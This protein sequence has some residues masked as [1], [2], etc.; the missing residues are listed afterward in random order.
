MP[1]LVAAASAP[2][3]YVVDF[4]NPARKGDLSG[5]WVFGVGMVLSFSFLC[6]RVYTK[7]VVARNFAIEDVCL[8]L[9][10]LA[11]VSVQALLVFMWLNKAIGV[12][13]YEM[14]V[15]VFNLYTK[16]IMS[17]FV[18]YVAC[19][20]LSKISL[21]LFYNRLSPVRWFRTAVYFLMF[22]VFAYSIAFIFAL[23][24]PCR[25]VARNWDIRIKDG[26]CINRAAIY[27][28]GAAVNITTD[29][30]LLALPI[31]MIVDL[32]M[33]KIQKAGLIFIF[34][35]G[36]MT[37][38][39]S[40]IRLKVILPLLVDNDETW[41][42]SVPCIWTIVEANLVIICGSFPITRQF[43][44]HVVPRWIGESS[45]PAANS[46]YRSRHPYDLETIGHRSPKKKRSRYGMESLDDGD[47]DNDLELDGRF[48]EHKVEI[49]ATGGE[50]SGDIGEE[51]EDAG[52]ETGIVKTNVTKVTFSKR[53]TWED[54]DSLAS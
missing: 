35:V 31:P 22:I 16:I 25:P 6:M 24:F 9:A 27:T 17:A 2:A 38:V 39:T 5:Y 45:S 28:A 36:S 11:G 48:A 51:V 34:M 8:I 20:G 41:E 46:R 15:E 44:K 47:N 29:I 50:R 54:K 26:E 37:C 52:S 40:I 53:E 23:I 10:W 14:P 18:I 49:Q 1:S 33:P 32:Q 3:G 12:H 4:A 21:L 43:L 19:L 7:V 13:I 30:A 42:V